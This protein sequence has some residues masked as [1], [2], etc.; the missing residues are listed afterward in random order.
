VFVAFEGKLSVGNTP[1][2][3]EPASIGFAR[4]RGAACPATGTAGLSASDL[5]D[6]WV[7]TE[8]PVE[9]PVA[10]G[11]AATDPFDL[12]SL[13]VGFSELVVGSTGRKVR[14]FVQLQLLRGNSRCP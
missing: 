8:L 13:S 7:A 14:E 1:V 5:P 3:R 9:F 2:S 6:N 11:R 12:R 4:A 10:I